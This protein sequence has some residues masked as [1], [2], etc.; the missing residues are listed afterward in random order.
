MSIRVTAKQTMMKV[1]TMAGTYRYVLQAQLYNKLAEAKVIKEAALR[2]G[3][4]QGTI[5]ASWAAIGEVIKAWATEGHSVAIPGLGTMRFGVRA[6]SVAEVSEVSTGLIKTRRVIFTPNVDIKD[7]LKNTS[8]NITCYDKDGN[9]VKQV[10]S[11]DDGSVEDNENGNG[12]ENGGENE[13]TGG[14][15]TTGGSE[16]NPGGEGGLG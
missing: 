4:A 1:G 13:N 10:T 7:E 16:D 14:S 12:N 9:I 6:S 15:S 5:N 2:S 8:I 11:D 3:I